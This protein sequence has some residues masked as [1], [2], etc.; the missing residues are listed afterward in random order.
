MK[1]FKKLVSCLLVLCIVAAVFPV[2]AYAAS[3]SG[4]CGDNVTWA[5]S[6]GTLTISGTGKMEDYERDEW[7][8]E[9]GPWHDRYSED[10]TKV[11]ISDGV[12]HI[13]QGAFAGLYE[14]T[15]VTMGKDVVSIGA[16][17]FSN[18][19]S[20]NTLTLG[21][22]VA[23]IGQGAFSGSC[24]K[25]VIAD[26]SSK[27]FVNDKKNV[28]YTKDMRTIIDVP[29]NYE[30]T[31]TVPNTVRTIGDYAFQYCYEMSGVTISENVTSIG[32]YAFYSCMGLTKVTI[33]GNVDSI[34][35]SA[36]SNCYSLKSVT[37]REGVTTIGN[38]AF[39]E[40]WGL[41]SADVA[42][43]VRSIGNFAFAWTAL[44]KIY[45]RGDAPS[46]KSNAFMD[47]EAK[48]YYPSGNSTWTSKVK[49]D[50]DGKLTWTSFKPSA[51]NAPAAAEI[52][53]SNVAS[54][55]KIKISWSSVKNAEQYRVFRSTSK[56]GTYSLV[57]TVTGTSCT[58]STAKAG[59]SYYYY[60]IS[61]GSDGSISGKS[62]IIN[63]TCDLA[64]PVV[65]LSNV[66][67][68][69]KIKVSWE[70][71]DGAVK[72]EVY[73]ATS[74]DGEYSKVKTTTDLSFTNTS[75]KAGKTYY[76]Q[77][78]AI[79]EKSA[80]DSALSS[81]KSRTCDLARP[82]VTLSNVA[83]SGKI[84][85]SWE[86]VDDAVKYEVYR[87]TSKDGEYSLMKT[88]T[89]TSYT[90]TSAKAGQTYYYKVKAIA[91]NSGANSALS[92][93]KSRTCDL[94]SPVAAVALNDE[95][96]P[97]VTWNAVSSAK[98]YKVY[99]Y[100]A[101]GSKLATFATADC[102]LVHSDAV[103]GETYSYDVMAVC[104]NSAGNSAKSELVSIRS[105]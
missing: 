39:D 104:S 56:S 3:N 16:F 68:S 11:V 93:V 70:K 96:K 32:E 78:K 88:T 60:V 35:A 101:N 94:A 1:R 18:C 76:Y 66:A 41:T 28:L 4:S 74:K 95:G 100:D 99:V 79:A 49:K 43:T 25:G 20:L 57:E 37:I 21:V 40:C 73:R 24:Y 105:N 6:K 38:S 15:K 27:Y 2:T 103:A 9:Y 85:V 5:Y 97:V 46:I 12:T 8:W 26:A 45:F 72:Y 44:Q 77:V 54:S 102:Q 13:G 71:V 19:E 61:V 29:G 10:I 63:R 62:N 80:A 53:S 81:A 23:T 75:A 92:S 59:K 69:G 51:S 14:L 65:T 64:R 33:P 58:D 55:G 42:G 98:E 30:G 50:Y 90:N 31:Y 17:A 52:K 7:D 82:T 36:F 34:G 87:A 91:E 47:V 86:K 67:S 83:S 84:K 48:A 89:S 22:N